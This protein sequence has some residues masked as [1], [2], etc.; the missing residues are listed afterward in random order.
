MKCVSEKRGDM[1]EVE[2]SMLDVTILKD[3]LGLGIIEAKEECVVMTSGQVGYSIIHPSP[4][5]TISINRNN[6]GQIFEKIT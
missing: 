6:P 5:Y 1:R 4:R 3:I 2:M